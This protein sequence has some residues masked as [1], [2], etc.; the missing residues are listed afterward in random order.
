M[1]PINKALIERL[2]DLLEEL[3]EFDENE[4]IGELN[5]Q[6]EDSLMLLTDADP[7]DADG[8]E[9]ISD[10]LDEIA[11][12][13]DRYRAFADIDATIPQKADALEAVIEMIRRNT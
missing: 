13:I 1:K 10:A 11:D 12:L 2:E 4:D 7:E 5:A 9:E 3:D 6:F 8:Q